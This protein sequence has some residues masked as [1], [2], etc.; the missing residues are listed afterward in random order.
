MRAA[1]TRAMGYELEVEAGAIR[2]ETDG[3]DSGVVHFDDRRLEDRWQ[4]C[5]ERLTAALTHYRSLRGRVSS[6]EPAWQA[7][8]L[9]VA[10]ARQR[11]QELYDAIV[12]L[13][14]VRTAVR[15]AG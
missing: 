6:S 2:P 1:D 14:G 10:E 7:A 8:Q 4:R 15:P 9:R 12:Q 5:D 11:R 13:H 3:D